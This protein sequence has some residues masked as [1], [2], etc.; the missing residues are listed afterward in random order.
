MKPLFLSQLKVPYETVLQRGLR[1]SYDW[2]RWI[3]NAFPGQPEKTRDF[4]FRVD[5][6]DR[7]VRVLLLSGER[8]SD[9]EGWI[10]DTRE[11]MEAFL[12]HGT[13]RFQVRAN[14]TFRRSSD[15]RRIA[16][17]KE[18]ELR[19]WITRK[20]GQIG[21]KLRMVE[22]G[23]PDTET[24]VKDGKRGTHVAV[25]FHGVLEVTDPESFREG[26]GKGI[27]TAKGFGYGLLMLQPIQ[28]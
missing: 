21:A 7:T 28:L 12:E 17:Y 27:G 26:F 24:F 25:D 9:I 13:F 16:L 3:W 23:H 5:V 1:T 20:L 10:W 14:P 4:L 19:D 22:V 18:E 11:I 8:P 15:H 6:A 2:H